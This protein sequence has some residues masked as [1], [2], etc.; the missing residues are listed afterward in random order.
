MV[1]LA[2]LKAF[3]FRQGIQS[4]HIVQTV[5]QLDDDHPDIFGQ[6]DEHLAKIL[7]LQGGVLVEYPRYFGESIDDD[8]Y[9]LAK[10]PA[11]E[12]QRHIGVFNHIVQQSC[13]NGGGPEANL[14]GNDL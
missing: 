14:K 5:G 3:L 7:R 1:S 11:D 2:I 8:G 10:I 6:G 9:P 13:S 12:V 4:T